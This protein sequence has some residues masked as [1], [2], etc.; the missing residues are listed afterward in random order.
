VQAAAAVRP[1]L[2]RRVRGLV[3]EEERRVPRVPSRRGGPAAQGLAQ[4]R[5]GGARG[6]GDGGED[7]PGRIGDRC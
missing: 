4:G 1:Q 2:P 3:A 6:S 5:G 7:K